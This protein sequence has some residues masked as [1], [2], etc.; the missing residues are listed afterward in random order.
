[1]SNE[2]IYKMEF[3]KIYP[4]LVN[5]AERKGRTR[6]EVDEVITWLTGYTAEQIASLSGSGICYGE[7]FRD[8]PAKN[9]DRV[10]ITGTVCGVRVEK[11]EDEYDLKRYDE[12]LKKYKENPKTYSLDEVEKELG[13]DE[14]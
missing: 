2:K 5:K 13:L 8:A 12:A 11:I 1:M 6:A 9:P 14:I 7:F 10:K 3:S 4:L